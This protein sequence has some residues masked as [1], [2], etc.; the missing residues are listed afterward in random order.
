MLVNLLENAARYAPVGSAVEIAAHAGAESFLLEVRDRG[1][2]IAPEEAA[3][4]FD[5]FYRAMN[6][7][8]GKGVG[9]GLAVA[10]GFVEAMGGT[11]AA[12]DRQGGGSVFRLTFPAELMTAARDEEHALAC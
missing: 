5:P 3:R 11:I 12:L 6:A 8:P 1:P 7:T 10:K 2:G 9:L 4:I